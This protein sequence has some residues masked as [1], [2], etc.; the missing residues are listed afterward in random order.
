MKKNKVKILLMIIFFIGIFILLYPFISQYHNSFVQSKTVADYE[1]MYVN[2]KDKDYS[3]LFEKAEKYNEELANLD[4]PLLEYKKLDGYKNLINVSNNGMMGYISIDKIKVEIPIYHGTSSDVLNTAVGHLEGT[5][6]PVGGKGTHSVLSAHRGLPS[7][8]LFTDLNK[9]ELG[10][11]FEITIVNRKLTYQ[12]DNITVIYPNDVEKLKIVDNEDYVTLVTCTPYG[13]NT[14]RLLVRGKRIETT[15]EKPIYIISDG[16]KI[17]NTVV[18]LALTIPIITILS[19]MIIL[20][21]KKT[22]LK[23]FEK[24][25]YPLKEL[26]N[27]KSKKERR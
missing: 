21:P 12:I 26:K 17:S 19:F 15:L 10:D 20:M 8:R 9:L 1:K 22:N 6:L 25:I 16:Y 2:A 11:T 4:Y 18:I 14:H 13:I 23:E 7:A 27:E 3:E 24:Y 5:S